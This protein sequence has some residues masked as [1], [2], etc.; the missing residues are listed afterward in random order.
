[1]SFENLCSFDNYISAHIALGKL[2]EEFINCYLVDEHS[3]TITPYLV[4]SLGG[5]KLMVDSTQAGRARS[6]LAEMEL[7]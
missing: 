4:N 7:E 3:A 2:Q 5:I 1:M 6:L